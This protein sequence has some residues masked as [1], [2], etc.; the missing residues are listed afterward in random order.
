MVLVLSEDDD[1]EDD[2]TE[3]G[4]LPNVDAVTAELTR[5]LSD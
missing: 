4:V 3:A 1:D 5:P 2:A